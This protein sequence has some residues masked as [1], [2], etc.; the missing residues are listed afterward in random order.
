MLKENLVICIEIKEEKPKPEPISIHLE[1]IT[2]SSLV[3]P[4]AIEEECHLPSYCRLQVKRERK[5]PHERKS[6]F[7]R[8]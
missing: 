5:K 7:G 1:K 2:S 4:S 8:D 6:G 3:S